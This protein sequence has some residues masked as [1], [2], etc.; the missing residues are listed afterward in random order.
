[1]ALAQFL[2]RGPYFLKSLTVTSLGRMLK[3]PV[4]SWNNYLRKVSVHGGKSIST[5]IVLGIETSCD[6]TG[7]AVV[8]E[9]GSILG[10]ALHSQTDVHLKTGGIIPPVAQQLH[11]ENIARIV[12]HAVSASG[13]SM[14][15]ISAVATTVMPGLALSL[16]IGLKY[17]LE[18][19]KKHRKPFIPIHHMEAHALTVRLTDLVPFPF[20]VLL[21]SGGHCILAVAQGVSDFLLLGQTKDIAPGDMLDKVARSLS[22]HNHPECSGMTGGRAIE[23]LAQQGNIL[24]YKFTIPMQRYRD[25]AFSFAGLQSEI[26]RKISKEEKAEDLAAAALY[27][28]TVHIA[29]RTHRAILFCKEK[30]IIPPGKETLV[31]SGGVASNQYVRRSL[32]LLAD[33]TNFTLVCPPPRLCTDNGVM[34]AWNGIEKLS[35]GLD[36]FYNVEHFRYEPKAPLGTDIS[37]QV[38]EAFIKVPALNLAV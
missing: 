23:T 22:L 17:S 7:A 12:Q 6:D 11:Q 10:E 34:I 3:T 32:Q 5:K 13:V 8:D 14:E 35:V 28:M 2:S 24:R 9:T 38:K 25:C 16:G 1:M 30:G 27:T 31:V 4:C 20:L 21:V 37:E 29:E 33:A 15:D 18:L 36:I 19:V 26:T